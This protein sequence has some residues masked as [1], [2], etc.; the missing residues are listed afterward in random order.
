MAEHNDEHGHD[1]VGHVV[2]V[3]LLVK[4]GLALIVLTAI[5]VLAAQVDFSKW[6]FG[7]ARVWWGEEG[8]WESR[9]VES[10]GGSSAPED[11]FTGP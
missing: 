2:P 10:R 4:T 9:R 6:V 7:G 3:K 1:E 8:R 11:V 5:T